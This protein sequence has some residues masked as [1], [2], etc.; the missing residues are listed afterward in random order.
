[1]IMKKIVN[2]TPH[3]IVLNDGTRFESSGTIARVQASFSEFDS[4]GVCQQ[5]FGEVQDLPGPEEGTMYVVSGL[6]LSA[7]G[8]ART[9]VVAPA[10]GHP[11]VVRNDKGQIVSVPGF[12]QG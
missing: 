8:G 12:V 5:V 11:K 2:L 3:A 9:D 7:L 1:M 6:V 10:T 4:D